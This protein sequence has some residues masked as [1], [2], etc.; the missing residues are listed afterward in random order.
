MNSDQLET[1][2]EKA[3]AR[4]TPALA[5][6]VD[7]TIVTVADQ[8][9]LRFAMT[10]SLVIG[11]LMFAIKVGAY[12][13]TGS[14]AILSDAAESVVHVAAVT[15]AFYSLRLSFKPADEGHRYGHAKISFFSAGFEGA[16][17]LL[18]ALYIAFEAI[19]KLIVGGELENLGVGTLLTVLAMLINGGLGAYLVATGRRRRSLILIAN[20]KHVLTDCWTSLGVISGLGLTLGTGWLP[21]DPIA[22]LVVAGNIMF[23]GVGL[24]RQSFRGLMDE[25]DP[26]IDRQLLAVL[27]AQTERYGIQFHDVRH[28]SLGSLYWVEVHL[29]FPESQTIGEAHRTATAIENAVSEALGVRAYV[30]THLEAIEDHD[31]IHR[32]GQH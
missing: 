31:R 11:L 14:A 23:S 12:L 27:E 2:Q 15:F 17:I 9:A 30:T 19:R 6:D 28:R 5:A 25:A 4:E 18:A 29:L 1:K 8:R 3:A 7:Q 32:P 22:A 13:L 26:E 24:I 10:L 21:W 16:M 20:G